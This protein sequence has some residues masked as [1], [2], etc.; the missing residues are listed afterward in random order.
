MRVVVAEDMMLTREGIARLLADAGV[1]VVAE[2]GDADHLLPVVEKMRPD[3]VLL[4][5]R[6]PPTHT[7]EGIVAARRIRVAYPA[8]GVL[9][10][11]QYVEPGWAL[12]LIEH[13]PEGVG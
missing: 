5:I 9:I 12:E 3:A 2:V 7:D 6:M 1:S 4:D 8:I 13:N 11:S 10:L